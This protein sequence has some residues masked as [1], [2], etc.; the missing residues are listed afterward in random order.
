[1]QLHLNSVLEIVGA[2]RLQ[3]S[4]VVMQHFSYYNCWTFWNALAFGFN[5]ISAQSLA[6]DK[7]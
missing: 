5:A 6:L 4:Y 3:K 7:Y 1:M 2:T